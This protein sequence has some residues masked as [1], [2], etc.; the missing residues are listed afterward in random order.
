MQGV[1]SERKKFIDDNFFRCWLNEIEA[2]RIEEDLEKSM[3]EKDVDF[4]WENSKP[5]RFSERNI[6]F[7]RKKKKNLRLRRLKYK[8]FFL[9]ENK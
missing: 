1:S 5:P 3:P 7:I 4:L 6:I 9:Y 2:R 8:S